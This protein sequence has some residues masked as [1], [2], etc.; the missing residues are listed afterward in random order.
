MTIKVKEIKR[1]NATII[2]TVNYGSIDR[3]Y[4]YN[5]QRYIGPLGYSTLY[6][7]YDVL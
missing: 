4:E 2:I 5:G 3:M 6:R 7:T 1:Y